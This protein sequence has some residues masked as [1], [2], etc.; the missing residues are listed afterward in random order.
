MDNNLQNLDLPPAPQ[1]GN[2]NLLNDGMLPQRDVSDIPAG[3]TLEL[4][5]FTSPLENYSW[6]YIK[7]TTMVGFL[8]AIMAGVI[9]LEVGENHLGDHYPG[10]LLARVTVYTQFLILL[11]TV[12]FNAY[13]YFTLVRTTECVLEMERFEAGTYA[14]DTWIED[15]TQDPWDQA[16]PIQAASSIL[17]TWRARIAEVRFV[18]GAHISTPI[19]PGP[20]RDDAV[21]RARLGPLLFKIDAVTFS[22]APVHFQL[23]DQLP[24]ELMIPKIHQLGIDPQLLATRVNQAANS[25]DMTCASNA[26]RKSALIQARTVSNATD[27]WSMTVAAVTADVQSKT[28][29]ADDISGFLMAQ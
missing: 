10:S 7:V 26:D 6:R 17:S 1:P 11:V 5:R 18:N 2:G 25:I 23:D 19:G 15:D 3:H 29:V 12:L 27:P 22:Y 20:R 24:T 13:L 4:E 9:M 14:S 8:I 28:R 16:P 21:K